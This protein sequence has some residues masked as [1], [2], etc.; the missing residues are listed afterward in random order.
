MVR[1]RLLAALAGVAL[2]LGACGGEPEVI[3]V[4]VP[5]LPRPHHVLIVL[6]DTLRADHMAVYGYPRDTTPF[7]DAFLEQGV[8]FDRAASQS[9]WTA[10]SVISMFTGRDVAGES[11]AMPADLP[12]MA[13]LF[14]QAG[15][16]T[17]A[18]VLNPLIQNRENDFHRGFDTFK[19]S[20]VMREV[21]KWIWNS[22]GQDTLTY[23]HLV[24]THDPYAIDPQ[25]HHFT[26]GPPLVPE[27]IEERWQAAAEGGLELSTDVREH[28]EQQRNR[29]D[30]DVRLM[31]SQFGT[32]VN[33][34]EV[35]GQ[36]EDAV[37]IL[38]SDHG[39]GLW[40]RPA[41][42]FSPE[43]RGP[44]TVEQRFKMTHGGQV[45]EELT[46]VPLLVWAPGVARG[47]VVDEQVGN[48][49]LLPTLLELADLPLPE[50]E[51]SGRSLAPLLYADAPDLSDGAEAVRPVGT[52]M[53]AT[54]YLH[55]LWSGPYKLIRPTA[56]G[57]GEGL[58]T[59]L[60]DLVAD[61]DESH[62][63]AAE[64]PG[65]VAELEAELEARLAGSILDA[66]AELDMTQTNLEA[67]RALG[68]TD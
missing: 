29:Y 63:L 11:L 24:T 36:L 16:R 51:L 68:Y 42:T 3:E 31:D 4:A 59:E 45:Y 39:E 22:Q 60:Y 10:P 2:A 49:D 54:R 14:Q 8:R 38:C 30:D 15:Y 48:V 47:R 1:D 52:T 7:L 25:F 5:E 57:R 19:T 37:V 61:P 50:G 55:A 27:A 56:L 23:V 20:K 26:G 35:T 12:A 34:L 43:A 67:M 62:D 9:S 41:F 64:R 58:E 44:A 46:R 18:F 17:G 40:T 66:D 33:Y 32:I 28:M 53:S 65:L 6:V 13:E 21:S